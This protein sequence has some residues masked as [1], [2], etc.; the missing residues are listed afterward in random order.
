MAASFF[1]ILMRKVLMRTAERSGISKN[2]TICAFF[3]V[4]FC[5]I[6]AHAS[7]EVNLDYF[8]PQNR[9]MLNTV[10]KYHLTSSTF[11]KHFNAREYVYAAQELEFVLRYFPNHPNALMLFGSLAQIR[12]TQSLAIAYYKKALKF[13]PHYA[14]THAQFGSYLLDLGQIDPGIAK[15]NEAIKMDPNLAVAHAWLAKA[16]AKHGNLE[17]ARQE[18]EQA[19]KLGYK[20]EIEGLVIKNTPKK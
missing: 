8:D 19:R 13:Y 2:I 6:C 20:G 7:E 18:A 5:F 3:A 17:T 14:I 16:Y 10:E 4:I 11:W 1:I 9:G 12:N 15:L